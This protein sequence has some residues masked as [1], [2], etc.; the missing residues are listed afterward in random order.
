MVDFEFNWKPEMEIN[1]ESVDTQ[2][3]QL[4]TYGRDIEQAIRINC[5]GVSEEK[6]VD[7]VCRLRE[8]VSYNTYEEEK[9]M[10]E[11]SYP[12]MDIHLVEHNQFMQD[13]MTINIAKLK[14]H[15]VE[16]LKEIQNIIV[17]YIFK[18]ILIED[19][20]MGKAYNEYL[21]KNK[22]KASLG[23]KIENK[24]KETEKEKI[25][26]YKI[27]NLD[28]SEI[29]LYKNQAREGEVVV[30]YRDKVHKLTK[31][32]ALARSSYFAD[33]A[34]VA[35]LIE[36]KYKPDGVEY[37]ALEDIEGFLAFHI[38]PKRNTDSDWGE[39]SMIRPNVETL[40]KEEINE[41]VASLEELFSY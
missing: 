41:R 33:L 18:H 19:M 8:Y 6:L 26:G 10:T 38:I 12:K 7:L 21:A 27:C 28:V 14:E 39:Q 13:I 40:S 23:E 16:Y 2:H 15:P 3:K 37:M 5:V 17:S 20:A 30:V 25:F 22:K 35:K 29:Y 36:E 4:F 34:R 1:I 31:L 11:M 9:I 32:N 24:K